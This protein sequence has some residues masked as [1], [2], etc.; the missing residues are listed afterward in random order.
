MAKKI[1]YHG[2]V[3]N[4]AT[5]VGTAATIV[6]YETGTSTPITLYTDVDGTAGSN[7]MS[8]DSVGRF[9]FFADPGIYDI[10]VSGAGITS[11]TLTGISL[12]LV[13]S[14][15]SSGEHRVKDIRANASTQLVVT[16]DETAES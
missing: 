7:P 5:G 4:T 8:T 11:Y 9:S 6:V 12:N 10:Q 15:P 14:D 2:L 13:T 16:Y 1:G 3:I